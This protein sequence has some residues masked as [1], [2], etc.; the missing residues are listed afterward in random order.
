M[1]N[2]DNLNKMFDYDGV[3][4]KL[5]HAYDKRGNALEG[6]E[7]GWLN[8]N[9]YREVQ[10]HFKTYKLHRVVWSMLIGEIPDGL[11]IDHINHNRSDNRLSNLRL[12]GSVDNAKNKSKYINNGSG[13]NGVHWHKKNYRWV[14]RIQVSG[15][16]IALG[17]FVEFHEAVNARKNAEVLYGFHE[18]HGECNVKS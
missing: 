2:I 14:A 18:N 12:V 3:D 15:K 16:R 13:V 10:I 17:C 5:Y 1:L 11:M 8:V 9:G 4:G 7:A 6:V